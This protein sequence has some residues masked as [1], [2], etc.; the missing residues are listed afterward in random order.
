MLSF[1]S[2]I[3]SRFRF[4]HVRSSMLFSLFE[5]FP[6][7]RHFIHTFHSD[8]LIDVLVS[9][10]IVFFMSSLVVHHFHWFSR[11]FSIA[12]RVALCICVVHSVCVWW[13]HHFVIV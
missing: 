4:S 10:S 1:I 11:L 7:V 5:I 3:I 8:V 12:E 9:W 2:I 6:I 13:N